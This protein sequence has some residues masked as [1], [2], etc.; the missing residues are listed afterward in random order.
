MFPLTNDARLI[1][2]PSA[3]SDRIRVPFSFRSA[4]L[5][6]DEGPHGGGR[7]AR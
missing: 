6:V 2:V 3:A 5:S 7:Y 4:V 1:D